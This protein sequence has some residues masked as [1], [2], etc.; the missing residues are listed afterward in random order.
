METEEYGKKPSIE[1]ITTTNTKNRIQ[2][3][4]KNQVIT[5]VTAET[6]S[7]DTTVTS[8]MKI[9]VGDFEATFYT[10]GKG[11]YGASVVI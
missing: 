5:E 4:L 10:G 3:D 7:T 8:D 9:S 2:A 1:T 11:T 6:T